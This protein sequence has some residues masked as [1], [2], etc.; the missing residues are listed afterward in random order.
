MLINILASG[1]DGNSY[2]ISDCKTNILIECGIPFGELKIGTNF[3]NPKIDGCLISHS[4]KDHSKSVN[5]LLRLG[6]NC[7]MSAET[8]EELKLNSFRVIEIK[9]RYK[10]DIGS[11]TVL[12]L[13]MKHDVSCIGFLIY[14]KITSESLFFATDTY[15]IPYKLPPVDYIMVEANYDL[16]RINE[17]IANGDTD[18]AAK[19]RLMQSHMNIDSTLLWLSK[20]DL[21]ITKRIYLLHLSA[22][23]ANEK[24]FKQRVIEQ[25]GIPVTI[26]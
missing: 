3:F 6:I 11:F 4:H 8:K 9:D 22:G 13:A 12:P 26:C 19:P 17:R 20:T 2:I 21:S 25:T 14:S 16:Q 5:N 18:M 1:S 15:Y 10:F 23:S 7:Y 24:D